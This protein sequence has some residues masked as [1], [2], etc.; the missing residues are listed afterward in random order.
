MDLIFY[1]IILMKSSSY[2]NNVSGN[3]AN[4]KCFSTLHSDITLQIDQL[5][6][7]LE[8]LLAIFS[9]IFLKIKKHD[10]WLLFLWNLTMLRE[11]WNHFDNGSNLV[12]ENY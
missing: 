9:F 8:I 10:L 11:D 5:F 1:N 4:R 12:H 3:E 7:C 6:D 2:Y